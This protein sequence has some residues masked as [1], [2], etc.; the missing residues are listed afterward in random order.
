MLKIS[1]SGQVKALTFYHRV[2]QNIQKDKLKA[3]KDIEST[4]FDRYSIIQGFTVFG[5]FVYTSPLGWAKPTK[6]CT[7]LK[8]GF[9][10]NFNGRFC[11]SVFSKVRRQAYDLSSNILKNHHQWRLYYY[12]ISCLLLHQMLLL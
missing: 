6:S 8:V 4:C 11:L 3:L 5:L 12:D 10:E 1:F 2:F 7:I 9:R